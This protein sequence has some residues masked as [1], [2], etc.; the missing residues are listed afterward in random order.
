MPISDQLIDQL[1]ADYQSPEDLLGEQGILKQ[2]TKKLAE[3]ALEA[4]MEQHLGYA[5][6]DAAS[7][8]TGNSRNGKRSK[9][10]YALFTAVNLY[11]KLI[12]HLRRHV[13]NLG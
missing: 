11:S 4:E 5:K 6:H 9:K 1:L 8:I 10:L 13:T 2:L 7:K 12:R 3:R